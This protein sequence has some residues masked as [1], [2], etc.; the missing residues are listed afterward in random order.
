MATSRSGRSASARK[1]PAEAPKDGGVIRP[2][3]EAIKAHPL[4]TAA[5][6][7]AGGAVVARMARGRKEAPIAADKGKKSPRR[8][9]G[10]APRAASGGLARKV[11][12][13]AQLATV[14]G[15]DPLT[16]ADIT[17]R[18]WEYIKRNGLQDSANRRMINA[19]DRLR[20]IFGQEQVSMFEMTRLV[21]QHVSS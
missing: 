4:A 15:G 3:V 7:A 20:P 5:A 19:D 6:V 8:A 18:L 14:V 9:A 17:K 10:S 2:L 21:S 16:R 12:P 11:T 1:A 13:D